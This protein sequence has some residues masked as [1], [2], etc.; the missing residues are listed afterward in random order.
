MLQKLFSGCQK[1][2]ITLNWTELA[3]CELALT[4]TEQCIFCVHAQLANY[5]THTFSEIAVVHE[6]LLVWLWLIVVDIHWHKN[7]LQ[8]FSS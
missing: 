6:E 1:P 5:F 3:Q 8:C 4:G 2:S 7:I